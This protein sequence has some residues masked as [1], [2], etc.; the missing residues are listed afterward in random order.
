MVEAQTSSTSILQLFLS[1][2][3]PQ[4]LQNIYA[5]IVVHSF[6]HWLPFIHYPWRRTSWISS[7]LKECHSM[8]KPWKLIKWWDVLFPL[9]KHIFLIKVSVAILSDVQHKLMHIHCLQGLPLSEVAEN[10]DCKT[11]SRF[12]IKE[13]QMT[14]QIQLHHHAA[15]NFCTNYRGVILQPVHN[16][17]DDTSMWTQYITF[18][19]H[20][21]FFVLHNH[22]HLDG[23]ENK[24]IK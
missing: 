3:S 7:I 2:T 19:H 6:T 10:A 4:T 22:N 8:F 1:Y 21:I 20:A 18:W 5:W 15:C 13:Q 24:F 12:T 9:Q 14:T 23:Y 16:L 11:Q 17:P